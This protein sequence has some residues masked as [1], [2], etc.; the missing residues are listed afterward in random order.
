MNNTKSSEGSGAGLIV[1]AVIAIIGFFAIVGNSNNKPAASDTSTNSYRGSYSKS[2]YTAEETEEEAEEE[3]E[4]TPEVWSCV[5]ATSYDRNSG[6]D[7]HCTSN[8]GGDRYVDDCTA[9]SLDP[10]Y[11]PSQRGASYYN[12]CAR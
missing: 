4:I 1:V 12:G 9:V 11:H 5:D 7:N 10:T 8:K 6:N 2:L 3:I